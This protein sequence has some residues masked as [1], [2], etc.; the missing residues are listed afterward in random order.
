MK[1][2]QTILFPLFC[3][4]PELPQQDLSQEEKEEEEEGLTEQQLCSQERNSTLDQENLETPQIKEEQQE[5]CCH[6]QEEQ[7]VLKQETETFVVPPI[8]EEYDKSEDQ[9]LDL[10]HDET[11]QGS[12]VN[13][14]DQDH[15]NSNNEDLWSTKN[16]NHNS[17]Q[18][19]SK[20]HTDTDKKF[21]CDKCGKKF[22]ER[23]NVNKHM[24]IHNGE[25]NCVC[26]ICG[27]GFLFKSDLSIHMRVHTGER[28][29]VC[30]TCGKSFTI[31]GALTI[32]M[33]QH[34]GEMPFTCSTCGQAFRYSNSL[35][36]HMSK[37]HHIHMKHYE[38]V[39]CGKTYFHFGNLVKHQ[40]SHKD[41]A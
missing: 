40:E 8:D 36:V 18:Q 12:V 37:A 17:R 9:T 25:K 26:K 4:F 15:K 10:D 34:T 39:I 2:V 22:K 24:K 32:H 6:Q 14:S 3:V 27:K 29:Y 20:S 23:F 1:Q 38:C 11:L 7:F 35:S 21:Q 33:R 16:G 5:V 28:P 30:K 41:A 19:K 13:M 31:R